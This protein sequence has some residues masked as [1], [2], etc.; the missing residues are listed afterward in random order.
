LT[1]EL[2]FTTPRNGIRSIVS[3]RYAIRDSDGNAQYIVGVIE[4]VTERK[5]IENKISHMARHDTL[6]G[7]AN[8]TLFMERIEEAGARLRRHGEAFCVVM[9]DLDRFKEVNDTFGHP[10]GDALLQDVARRLKLSLRETDVLAR[11]GGD[12]FAIILTA[13][14]EQR[15]SAAM[16]AER[17][18]GAIA[19]PFELDENKVNVGASLGIAVAPDDG[20]SPIS[21]QRPTSRSTGPVRRPE[22][23]L[24]LRCRDAD[25]NARNDSSRTC[26]RQSRR[27][28]SCYRPS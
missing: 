14:T 6:T 5:R 13:E 20:D 2:Q 16:I 26:A 8:R 12:E 15:N 23:P 11:L 4:D 24:F 25:L 28:W 22:P 9:L 3:K 10:A 18:I 7:L 21:G 1:D 27:N 17:I 19:E